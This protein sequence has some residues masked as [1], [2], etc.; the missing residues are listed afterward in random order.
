MKLSLLFFIIVVVSSCNSKYQL[1][2]HYLSDAYEK[3]IDTVVYVPYRKGDKWFYIDRRTKGPYAGHAK[4]FDG[5]WDRAYAFDN[6]RIAAVEKNG[7]RG[8]ID[9]T[10]KIIIPVNFKS[11][12]VDSKSQLIV[13]RNKFNTEGVLSIRGDTILP[14]NYQGVVIQG[15]KLKVY[16]NEETF[17]VLN[18]KGDV[19]IE[20]GELYYLGRHKKNDPSYIIEYGIKKE[21]ETFYGFMDKD[22]TRITPPIFEGIPKFFNGRGVVRMKNRFGYVDSVGTVVIPC[23]YERAQLFFSETA[24]VYK[25]NKYGVIDKQGNVV[26]SLEYDQL[27]LSGFMNGIIP[28]EKN[29]K[30]GVINR[31]GKVLVDFIYDFADIT[32]YK[33]GLIPVE[34]NGLSGVIDSIGNEIIKIMYSSEELREPYFLSPNRIIVTDLKSK[35]QGIVTRK[36]KQITPLKYSDV[37]YEIKNGL[38]SVVYYSNNERKTGYIDIWGK[39]YFED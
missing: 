37:G 2:E 21:G 24:V 26:I 29:S 34:K 8:F 15:D 38:V 27:G 5:D 9:T 3:S 23:I 17:E 18:L 10:G 30:W 6:N 35:K 22:F 1:H 11:S 7:L 14:F 25:Y 39:E 13:L 20:L 32:N 16:H 12:V 31:E 4:A 28:A 33:Y 19:L 36:N